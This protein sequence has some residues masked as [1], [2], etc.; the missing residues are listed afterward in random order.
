MKF[1]SEFQPKKSRHY[2]DQ[3]FYENL[4]L[5]DPGLPDAPGIPL[6]KSDWDEDVRDWVET[7]IQWQM[8]H[9][10]DAFSDDPDG[11]DLEGGA[12]IEEGIKEI[13]VNPVARTVARRRN[14]TVDLADLHPSEMKDSFLRED[15]YLARNIIAEAGLW[16]GLEFLAEDPGSINKEGLRWALSIVNEVKNR[17][18]I[19]VDR[20]GKIVDIDYRED[21]YGYPQGTTVVDSRNLGW[22]DHDGPSLRELLAK[23]NPRRRR[24]L[25]RY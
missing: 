6:R 16:P 24:R 19:K 25:K 22:R 1:W 20:L 21:T 23:H 7:V 4:R 14:P 18:H 8:M 5:G 10:E 13:R 3:Y 15:Y 2:L 12:K 17:P 11:L 9:L